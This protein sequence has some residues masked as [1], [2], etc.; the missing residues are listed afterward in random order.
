M[1]VPLNE[2]IYAVS[3]A[4]DFVEHDLLGVTSN[5]G[6]RVGLL[7]GH[8]C[9]VLGMG[10]AE[11]FDMAGCA[12]LHDSAL[13]AYMLDAGPG[14]IA[15]LEGFE[16]HCVIGEKNAKAF[17]WLGD[18]AGIVLY[19]HENW[20]GTG[21]QGLAGGQIPLRA[22]ILRLADNMDLE[23][24]MGD[25]RP[26]LLDE[27]TRHARKFSGSLYSPL[28]V[29]AFCDSATDELV[30]RLRDENVENSLK[31]D[32][33][34]IQVTLS[35]A[36]MLKICGIFANIVDAKSHFTKHHSTGVAEKAA[37]MADYYRLEPEHRDKI[38][39]AAYLHDIGKLSIPHFILEK[40]GPLSPHERETMR[41]H[42]DMGVNL[43]KNV[44]GLE[45]I[46]S[47]FGGHHEKLNGSGYPRC[48]CAAEIPFET[49]L[50]ACCD[51]Y[52]ALTEDRPYRPGMSHSDTMRILN[53]MALDGELDKDMICDIDTVL[54]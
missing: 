2:L 11:I 49:R 32:V 53:A 1:R 46:C 36:Q 31:N 34:S 18:T 50:I 4:L 51:I 14:D 17:P 16:S 43:L 29:E 25:G 6:K 54:V 8:I 42:V 30:E 20:D 38:I 52:Q 21:F 40:N 9:R 24:R 7:A 27:M 13:T 12:M 3:Q 22:V 48:L 23:L 19:H 44:N 39:I 45:E 33:P 47:W 37:R 15:R 28:T 5:H 35:S 41:G 26:V 10:E